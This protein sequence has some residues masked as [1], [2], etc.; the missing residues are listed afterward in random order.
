MISNQKP[1]EECLLSSELDG[2]E[3]SVENLEENEERGRKAAG[4]R[5]FALLSPGQRREPEL[6]RATLDQR[7][8][9]AAS[10]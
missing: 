2:R 10:T 3:K 5:E 4:R 7:F 1:W 8:R 6:K 9:T